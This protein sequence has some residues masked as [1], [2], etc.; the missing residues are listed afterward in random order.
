[1][2]CFYGDNSHHIAESCFKALA[3]ALRTAVG[4]D[5]RQSGSVPSTKGRLGG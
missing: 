1:M 3:R 5:P 4:E 2:E